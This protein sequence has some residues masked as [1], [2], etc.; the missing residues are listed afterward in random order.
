MEYWENQY[1]GVLGEFSVIRNGRIWDSL[2]ELAL[3][4]LVEG[5]YN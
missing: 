3:V 2:G 5:G 1:V 4:V